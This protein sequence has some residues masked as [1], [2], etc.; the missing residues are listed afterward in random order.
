MNVIKL[1]HKCYKRN[2]HKCNKLNH[3]Y[4]KMATTPKSMGYKLAILI[5][6]E[7]DFKFSIRPLKAW[8]KFIMTPWKQKYYFFVCNPKRGPYFDFIDLY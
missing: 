6:R 1:A 2:N 5:L 4:N 3:K 7:I 8:L